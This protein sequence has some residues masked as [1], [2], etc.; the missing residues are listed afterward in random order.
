MA[1]FKVK[2]SSELPLAKARWEV[3]VSS[4][5]ASPELQL[6]Y[7]NLGYDLVAAAMAKLGFA[8]SEAVTGDSTKLMALQTE[9][10]ENG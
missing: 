3:D 1:L 8:M 4:G 10:D 6:I 7:T 5:G 2:V 9:T